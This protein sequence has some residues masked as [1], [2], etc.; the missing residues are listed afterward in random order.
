MIKLNLKIIRSLIALVAVILALP[1]LAIGDVITRTPGPFPVGMDI[2]YNNTTAT[3]AQHD[4]KLIVGAGGGTEYNSQVRFDLSGLPVMADIAILWLYHNSS[5]TTTPI[6]WYFNTEQWHSGSITWSTQPAGFSVGTS[7]APSTGWYGVNITSIYNVWRSGSMTYLNAGLSLKPD[8]HDT[9][10]D[11]FGASGNTNNDIRP[12]LEVNYTSNSNDN[13]PKHKWHLEIPIYG[14]RSINHPFGVDWAGGSYCDGLI[15]KH[16]G[17]DYAATVGTQVYAAEDGIVKEVFETTQWGS[18]IVMEHTSPTDDKYTTVY[19]H[20]NPSTDVFVSENGGFIPKGSQ[21]ATVYDLGGNT[22]SHVGVRRASYD[23]S[24]SDA[25]S[26]A[27][28]QTNC[29]GYLAFP[30]SFVDVN[31]TNNIIF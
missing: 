16:N 26:G 25:L 27:S 20:V 21:I 4:S 11:L 3:S 2:W 19:W 7:S 22:H 29:G 10:Y 23:S 5:Y 31:N 8:Q 6:N 17:V 1:V 30:A 13:I 24:P 9:K 28:P 14:D 18:A 12:R 15:K